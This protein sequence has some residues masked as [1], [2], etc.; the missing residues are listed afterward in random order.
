MY[1]AVASVFAAIAGGRYDL[2]VLEP[3][4]EKET[5]CLAIGSFCL[6]L[7]FSLLLVPVTIV[8]HLGSLWPQRLESLGTWSYFLPISIFC[9]AATSTLS[10]WL[11]R[12]AKYRELSLN[13]I[14]NSIGSSGGAALVG[15]FTNQASALLLPYVFS[16]IIIVIRMWLSIRG[17]IWN[18][19]RPA[20]LEALVSF[21]RYPLFLLPATFIGEVAANAP[22]L[23]LPIWFDPAVGGAFSIA[24]RTLLLPISVVGTVIGEVYR[25][26]AVVQYHQYG[27]CRK[28]FIRTF[29]ALGV[30]GVVPCGI[31][32]AF[33][34]PIF[35]LVFGAE[36]ES[37]AQ[38]SAPLSIVAFFQL[39][40][41][42]LAYTIVLNR[43]QSRDL[44]LQVLRAVAA[45]VA[46]YVGF[47]QNDWMTS[48]Y[49]YS[50]AYC[51]Y[52]VLH[53]LLQFRAA[54]GKEG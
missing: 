14:S 24:F 19:S 51:V 35:T 20:I 9:L 52:Y 5:S 34:K 38:V 25:E 43:S 46:L 48:V 40:S 41:T 21:K 2:A 54:S 39:L 22:L 27:N 12:H 1:V 28:L 23:L 26:Q 8:L 10:A 44:I 18:V 15:Q 4:S 29:I 31:I 30:I 45:I 17:H 36:W 42:P 33:G 3:K 7:A 6:A 47:L 50:I 53:S 49:L 16:Q 37:A 11:N 32:L 13:R